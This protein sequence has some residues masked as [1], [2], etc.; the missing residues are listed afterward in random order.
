ML[1]G[2]S[3]PYKLIYCGNAT[4][5]APAAINACMCLSRRFC[6][7]AASLLSFF[8]F[9]FQ[10]FHSLE[11]FFLSEHE[12]CNL[13]ENGL[14]TVFG[15]NVILVLVRRNHI[16]GSISWSKFLSPPWLTYFWTCPHQSVPPM[17]GCFSS[18]KTGNHKKLHFCWITDNYDEKIELDLL[19]NR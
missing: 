11:V 13:T 2:R 5:M 1:R 8:A 4:V 6:T 18:S 12:S 3:P 17:T 14:Y 7:L 15:P 19:N 10:A 9:L 16:V